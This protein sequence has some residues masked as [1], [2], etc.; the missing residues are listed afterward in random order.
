MIRRGRGFTLIELL[1]V[2]A[3]IGLLMALLLPA[4]QRVREASNRMRCGSNLRQLAIACHNFENDFRTLPRTGFYN[5][6]TNQFSGCCGSSLPLWSWIARLLPYIEQQQ[7]YNQIAALQGGNFDL[8]T[9]DQ[10]TQGQ[11]GNRSG[12]PNLLAVNIDVLFCPS[13]RAR[14]QSPLNN[15]ANIG[16]FLGLTNYAGNAGTNWCGASWGADS[17]YN[18]NNAQPPGP[19]GANCDV[20]NA[21]TNGLFSRLDIYHEPRLA[22]SDI[23]DGSSNTFMIG[24]QIPDLDVHAGGWAYSNHVTKTCW[25]PPNYR[26]EGQNPGPAPGSWP[27]VYS[28]RS[29]HIGGTQF[30]M[31][32]ASIRFI[33]AGIDINVYRAAA[34]KQGGETLQLPN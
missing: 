14:G 22:I 33:R 6:Q 13:D 26:M 1:V 5:P 18:V 15:R 27:S 20:F 23:T 28:F 10:A 16:H 24:E 32:D 11:G 30:V 12:P 31:A 8:V 7:L 19:L 9:L 17:P 34:T 2:I 29:R 4:I 21:G 25:I 3:I